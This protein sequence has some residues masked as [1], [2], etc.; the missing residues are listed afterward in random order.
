MVNHG[1]LGFSQ[2]F[3]SDK[4]SE[5]PDLKV[6]TMHIMMG[7]ELRNLSLQVFQGLVNVPILIH[8]WD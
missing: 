6:G 4:K 5:C 2:Y 1:I 3:Q 8:F 7:T